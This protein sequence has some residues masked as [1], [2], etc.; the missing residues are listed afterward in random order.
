MPELTVAKYKKAIYN[1]TYDNKDQSIVLAQKKK[2]A[3]N[4]FMFANI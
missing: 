4:F 2:K 3:S 1:D